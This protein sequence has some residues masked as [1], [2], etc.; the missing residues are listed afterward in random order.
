MRFKK[1][2]EVSKGNQYS[3]KK[4]LRVVKIRLGIKRVTIRKIN[5]SNSMRLFYKLSGFLRK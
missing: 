3:L 4:S 2:V 5:G 1:K